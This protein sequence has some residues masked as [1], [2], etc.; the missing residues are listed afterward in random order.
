VDKLK[1]RSV[2]PDGPMSSASNP[3]ERHFLQYST[4]R[5]LPGR[6]TLKK[7]AIELRMRPARGM[8]MAKDDL[9]FAL[10]SDLELVL[11]IEAA[12]LLQARSRGD[13]LRVCV[14]SLSFFSFLFVWSSYATYQ[15][16]P[17]HQR[18]G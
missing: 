5:T 4:R 11:G 13:V 17:S 9:Q 14:P 16:P 3:L 1:Q 7:H 15:P 18:I 12:V 2:M 10:L 8:G 6:R